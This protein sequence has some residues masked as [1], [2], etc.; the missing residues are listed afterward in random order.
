LAVDDDQPMLAIYR[1]VLQ[2]LGWDV[3]TVDTYVDA[4]ARLGEGD[5]EV[6]LVDLK[7]RGPEGPDEGL[8]LLPEIDRHCPG[9]KAIVVTGYASPESIERAFKAGVY[10]Y[11]EKTP[12]FGTLLRVKV[13]NAM[14]LQRQRWLAHV[15]DDTDRSQA[16][17]LWAQARVEPNP[18]RKGRLLEDLLELLLK[19]V[20]G[21][22]VTP[23]RTGIDEEFDLVVRLDATADAFWQQEGQYLIVEC[24]NWSRPTDPKELDRFAAKLERRFGRS[25]LGFFVAAG[26]FTEGFHTTLA[27]MRRNSILV[28]PIN[29][30]DLGRLVEA[31]D[32]SAVLKALHQRTIE[33]AADK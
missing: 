24:K 8:G 21:F 20:P 31:E 32:R 10:D 2:P 6:V 33:I 25:R 17:A 23:R 1:K 16:R 15:G 9:A 19:S 29:R 3:Q 26:D 12:T 7:L 30:D 27:A 28:V 14:E 13:E 11:L 18:H 4:V 22:F 5:W